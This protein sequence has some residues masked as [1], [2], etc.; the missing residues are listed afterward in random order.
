LPLRRWRKVFH[1][2]GARSGHHFDFNELT[3]ADNDHLRR[4]VGVD[5]LLCNPVDGVIYRSASSARRTPAL[6]QIDDT[7]MLD[8]PNCR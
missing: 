2:I 6:R 1:Q 4:R 5:E 8:L 3:H 7:L